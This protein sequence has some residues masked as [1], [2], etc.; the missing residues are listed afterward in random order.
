MEPTHTDLENIMRPCTELKAAPCL[1]STS[2][3]WL[4]EIVRML[5]SERMNSDHQVLF[6]AQPEV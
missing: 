5:A 4:K 2:L 1:L 6:G 3:L